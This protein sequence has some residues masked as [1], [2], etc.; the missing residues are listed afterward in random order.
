MG[1]SCRPD[2]VM[3][4]LSALGSVLAD[5]GLPIHV[6]DAEAAAH[7]AYA[8]MHAKAAK[9]KKKRRRASGLTRMPR[10][11]G[12]AADGGR[13]AIIPRCDTA[14]QRLRDPVCRRER[15][16]QP[17]RK[18]RRSARA[19]RDRI[20]AGRIAQVDRPSER[21]RHQD[22]R[23]RSHGGIAVGRRRDAGR[24]RYAGARRG[25]SADGKCARSRSGSAFISDRRSK[26]AAIFSAMR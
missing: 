12:L 3:L 11:T 10:N 16:H 9:V 25:H 1:Y 5:M 7:G 24:V 19:R 4:C 20:G 21:P 17:V 22:H 6:G 2:N 23:R 15:Q 26:K 8:P 13:H 14:S 18:A